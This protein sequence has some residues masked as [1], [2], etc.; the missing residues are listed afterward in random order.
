MIGVVDT[1]LL[2]ID[3]RPAFCP[4][5]R[6]SQGLVK[7]ESRLGQGTIGLGQVDSNQIDAGIGH[8]LSRRGLESRMRL[9]AAGASRQRRDNTKDWSAH[10]VG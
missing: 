8:I 10:R 6:S 9:A 5:S 2:P 3:T 1:Y 7:A 4:N